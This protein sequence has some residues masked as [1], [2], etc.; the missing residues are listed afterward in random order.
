MADIV[1]NPKA[2]R[3]Y[4]I[5]ET[6]EAGIVLHGTEVKAL[7]AG[8]AQISDAFARVEKQQAWLHNAH[9]DEYSWGNVNNHKPKAARKLLLHKSEIRKLAAAS[10]IKGHTL[11]P[12]SL[13]WKNG[14]VKVALAIGRGKQLFDKREDLKKREAE[15]RTQARHHAPIQ[16][17]R[18]AEA[19]RV[20]GGAGLLER[21]GVVGNEF[22]AEITH[23][24]VLR[25]GLSHITH[26]DLEERIQ[27]RA[28]QEGA[29]VVAVEVVAAVIALIAKAGKKVPAT[30]LFRLLFLLL[31]LLSL[32][33]LSP[34]S[35]PKVGRSGVSSV[36]VSITIGSGSIP[37][38]L[39]SAPA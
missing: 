39:L 27:R 29:V 1:N 9:I 24:P 38:E 4:E 37:L 34:K 12:L 30:E 26:P 7:R 8:K 13:Y 5:L 11:V 2:R 23:R 18:E 16:I 15:M 36:P 10:A 33:R 14:R 25:I 35:V 19:Q 21:G 32:S 20:R 3:D 6:F 28:A 22:D 31:R 17:F